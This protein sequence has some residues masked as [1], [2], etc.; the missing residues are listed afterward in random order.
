MQNLQC[1]ML[2]GNGAPV[3]E[4]ASFS[5]TNVPVNSVIGW[6]FRLIEA[7]RTMENY[8]LNIDMGNTAVDLGNICWLKCRISV[9]RFASSSCSP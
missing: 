8:R 1:G 9:C 5:L 4:F 3:L 7:C 6:D 2:D